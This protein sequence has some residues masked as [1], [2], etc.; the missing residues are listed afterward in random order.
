MRL[1][2]V[3]VATVL[4]CAGSSHVPSA[5]GDTF[6]TRV[7]FLDG[8]TAT[9]IGDV[10]V[11]LWTE[12]LAEPLRV[13]TLLGKVASDGDGRARIP[14]FVGGVRVEK[15]RVSRA[16]YASTE[17]GA[18]PEEGDWLSHAA[19]PRSFRVLDLEGRPIA[20]AA[21]RTRQSC[22]H[23]VPAVE[24]RTDADGRVR[25]ED[26]PSFGDGAELEVVADGFGTLSHE[27]LDDGA[28]AR[29]AVFFGEPVELRLARRPG[30][31]LE[32]VDAHGAPMANR[33]VSAVGGPSVAAWTDANG[34][35]LYPS[36]AFEREG[37]F[38]LADAT[39]DELLGGFE[40]PTLG[41]TRVSPQNAA[42]PIDQITAP[43]R[44]AVT[45]IH[46]GSF[47]YGPPR[48][49]VWDA[50]GR[51]TELSADLRAP[52]GTTR[53]VI[54]RR[55]SGWCQRSEDFELGPE[56]REVVLGARRE[57]TLRVTLPPR[58]HFLHLQAGDD[59]ITRGELYDDEALELFVPPDVP[60]SLWLEDADGSAYST[61]LA[62]LASDETRSISL[63]EWCVRRAPSPDALPKFRVRFEVPRELGR[64]RARFRRALGGE[65]ETDL[66][67]GYEL[68]LFEGEAYRATFST[69]AGVFR[70]FSETASIAMPFR[71]LELERR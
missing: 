31:R 70:D 47:S 17:V 59:S 22:E 7:R 19:V 51:M 71:H 4:G 9:P 24:G 64:V 26:F 18:A 29:R 32:L 46:R 39:G 11:E 56:G 27:L 60:V 20:G 1:S 23:A 36:S 25:F 45:G 15:L 2:L 53:V 55:F 48:I 13:P 38:Q 68:E 50:R 6:E 3:L 37:G 34:E 54:G 44:I 21:V 61:T 65:S 8:R 12:D 69:D 66:P 62:P 40:P 67:N 16:G 63:A 41:S 42:A 28:I 43:V 35:V 10:T 57:G 5:A 58:S 52:V 49:E 30:Y 33:R 14:L